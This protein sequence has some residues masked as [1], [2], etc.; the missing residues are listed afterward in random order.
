MP[1]SIHHPEPA[2]LLTLTLWMTF[3]RFFYIILFMIM[4]LAMT[5]S[6]TM[7]MMM[8]MNMITTMTITIQKSMNKILYWYS[9]E[10]VK[11]NPNMQWLHFKKW[12]INLIITKQRL[13]NKNV[14]YENL[15]SFSLSRKAFL[16]LSI[17][18]LFVTQLFS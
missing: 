16:S 9:R 4:T 5:M 15:T 11:L 1:Q 18:T 14:F 3:S 17:P 6:I 8:A 7:P 2:L 12:E 13:C 10:V